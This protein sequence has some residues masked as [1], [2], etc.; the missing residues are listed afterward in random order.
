MIVFV[1]CGGCGLFGVGVGILF[2][3][4]LVSRMSLVSLLLL[5]T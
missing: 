5:P 3:F 1:V 2:Y 4:S